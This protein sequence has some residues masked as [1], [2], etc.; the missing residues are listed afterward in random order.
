MR[1]PYSSTK[2]LSL[3]DPENYHKDP[4]KVKRFH[5]RQPSGRLSSRAHSPLAYQPRP[6]PLVV[7]PKTFPPS[8]NR[9]I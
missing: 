5:L 7:D 2:P 6:M 9:G 1:N 4:Q 3:N 8:K